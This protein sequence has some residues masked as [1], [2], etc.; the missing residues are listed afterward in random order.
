MVPVGPL[1]AGLVT[2][3]AISRIP[4]MSYMRIIPT[5]LPRHLLAS[6]IPHMAR[7]GTI[8]PTG[9][10]QPDIIHELIRTN[11]TIRVN[12]IWYGINTTEYGLDLSYTETH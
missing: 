7:N 2:E 4:D 10:M 5:W 9:Y 1:I 6:L 3:T 12:Y 11:M 8:A